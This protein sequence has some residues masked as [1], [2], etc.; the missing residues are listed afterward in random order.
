MT[1]I[2][3]NQSEIDDLKATAVDDCINVDGDLEVKVNVFDL[4]EL[5]IDVKGYIDARDIDAWNINARDIKAMDINA[6][7]I[8]ARDIK[9][10]D[11]NAQD[12]D[13]RDINAWNINAWDISYYAFC[14]ARISL[15]C[16]SIKGIRDNA[17]HK[18]LDSEIEYIEETNC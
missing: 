6:R 9:A 3:K 14:I 7:D 17:L 11:I 16:K 8:D 15:K 1:L 10:M 5:S 4:G 18:C 2:I 12:I 13:A